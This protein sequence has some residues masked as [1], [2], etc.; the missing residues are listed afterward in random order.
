MYHEH[1]DQEFQLFSGIAESVHVQWSVESL[2]KRVVDSRFGLFSSSSLPPVAIRL[3]S[4]ESR[5][6]NMTLGWFQRRSKLSFP[7]GPR[8]ETLTWRNAN[9][10]AAG[11]CSSRPSAR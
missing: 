1:F 3:Q 11:C 9:A 2:T 6:P 8:H 10:N 4:P 7:R 5:P